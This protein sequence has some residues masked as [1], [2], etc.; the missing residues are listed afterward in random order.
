MQTR[1][2]VFQRTFQR[3]IHTLL[4]GYS[5][6]S[7]RDGL[8]EVWLFDDL[9]S[10]CA[11]ERELAGHGVQARFRSA[12][13]PLIHFFLEEV[14]LQALTAV[15]VRYPS[16]VL[17]P[18]RFLLEA[19]PLAGLLGEKVCL[20]WEPV[21]VPEATTR[22]SHEVQ[23][24]FA[25]GVVEKHIV[26][27][28][29]RLHRDH[30]D[31]LLLSP[32]GWVSWRPVTGA[33]YDE[34]L[35]TD[36][37]QLFA[38]TMEA[39]MG[40]EWP[41]EEPYFEELNL[42]VIWPGRDQPLAYGEEHISL[43][44]GLHEDLYFSLLEYF[45]H[46]AGLP[47]GDRS[48]QPG[49]IMPEILTQADGLPSVTV[50]LQGLHKTALPESAG[51]L[52]DA[53]L[54][55]RADRPLSESQ[56]SAYLNT[57]GQKSLWSYSRGRRKVMARHRFGHDK[58]VLIS[59]AQHAN[60]TSGIV[61]ALRAAEELNTL[62]SAH[63]VISPLENPDGY[64]L[65]QRLAAEQPVHMHH[66]ARYTAFGND[67][68]AQPPGS[69]FEHA[70]REQ[71]IECSG[72]ELHVNLHGYPAHEW[73][74]PL[75]GYIPRNFEMWTIPKGFFLIIRHHAG[76]E[77]RAKQLL[78]AVTRDLARIAALVELN[79]RQIATFEVHAGELGFAILHDIPYLLMQDDAQLTP[80]MLITEYPDETLYGDAFVLAH[81]VQRATVLSAYRHY[82]RLSPLNAL[83]RTGSEIPHRRAR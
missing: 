74:R 51:V 67:L 48:I 44:E 63:F 43:A 23:L 47:L 32:C 76:W 41:S 37:E 68:Q 83:T 53:A 34:P 59:A 62:P 79:R 66:A 27:A 65:R 36:Y 55:D 5:G 7:F 73:T 40:R 3:S 10:R 24:T 2:L 4:A 56:I 19:Y 70:I 82:Q 8:L 54:L 52:L 1:Q 57:L 31:S 15:A 50:T 49:Q 26:T 13:K 11:A 42:R 78:E 80:L 30:V 6:P 81:E 29:N 46:R 45:Q 21:A 38:S 28:P 18:R 25:D 69:G 71:A 61:G 20:T 64:H 22:Y 39:V 14:D 9:E 12:Y 17:S 72:A 35:A 77:S 60:E 33:H 16:P 75:S 58:A